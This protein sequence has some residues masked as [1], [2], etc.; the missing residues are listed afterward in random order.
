MMIFFDGASR[1]VCC[2]VSASSQKNEDGVV[3]DD[4]F[5]PLFFPKK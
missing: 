5:L 4:D 1:C 3:K 2:A